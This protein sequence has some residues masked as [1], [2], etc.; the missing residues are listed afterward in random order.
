V[1]TLEDPL[2]KPTLKVDSLRSSLGWAFSC[3]RMSV[4]DAFAWLDSRV[5]RE[6]KS[7]WTG[8]RHDAETSKLV[9][10]LPPGSFPSLWIS[11]RIGGFG[12]EVKSIV[13]IGS[14]FGATVIRN[15]EKRMPVQ[16][17][18]LIGGS[19]WDEQS[20]EERRDGACAVSIVLELKRIHLHPNTDFLKSYALRCLGRG[21]RVVMRECKVVASGLSGVL[22]DRGGELRMEDCDISNCFEHGLFAVD[23]QRCEVVKCSF[24]LCKFSSIRVK[25]FE[26]GK[27]VLE[28]SN[29]DL[30]S[31]RKHNSIV[32]TCRQDPYCDLT[33]V[34]DSHLCSS[35][36]CLFCFVCSENSKQQAR[37]YADWCSNRCFVGPQGQDVERMQPRFSVSRKCV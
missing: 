31:D 11:E 27:S 18:L 29:C 1:W 15:E 19:A 6:K 25:F 12:E 36:F 7:C 4:A 17:V 28:I 14:N 32:L 9:F 3:K 13:L 21:A 22:V 5:N 2:A 23:A 10:L 24:S 16:C 34:Q 30:L 20:D 35:S 37:R 33:G 26:A 8:V